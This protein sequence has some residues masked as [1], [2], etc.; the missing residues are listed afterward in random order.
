[1]QAGLSSTFSVASPRNRC[2]RWSVARPSQQ[3]PDT[4]E[5]QSP[6]RRR[7]AQRR[8]EL[9]SAARRWITEERHRRL[10]TKRS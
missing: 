5:S 3:R 10:M 9:P 8:G 1:M 4:H 6:E 2:R 7:E